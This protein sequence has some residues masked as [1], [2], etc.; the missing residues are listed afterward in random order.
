[1][2]LNGPIDLFQTNSVAIRY[3]DVD[4]GSHRCGSP[5]AGIDIRQDSITGPVVATAN[6]ASTGGTGHL[7]DDHACR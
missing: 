3:A 2:Q 1:M 5:L 4:G 6:L 7:G